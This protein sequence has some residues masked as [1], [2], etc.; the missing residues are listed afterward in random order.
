MVN[1]KNIA[2]LASSKSFLDSRKQLIS[3]LVAAGHKV[4]CI[5]PDNLPNQPFPDHGAEFYGLPLEK[6][7]LNPFKDLQFLLRLKKMFKRLKPDMVL[8]YTI[9]PVIYGCI[10]ANLVGVKEINAIIAGL[11]Y[12][13]GND[14]KQQK[15]AGI[16][17]KNLYRLALRNCNQVIFQNPDDMQE[18]L[19][20]GIVNDRQSS[21]VNGS[22]V[23]L[24]HFRFT[25]PPAEPVFILIARMLR[26]KG[27]VEFIEAA[28]RLK[29]DFPALRF[30]IVGPE[31]SGPSALSLAQ[32][33]ALAA[34]GDIEVSGKVD[35]VRPVLQN[36]SLFVLP[37]YYREGVPRIILEAMAIGRAIVT[38]DAPGCRETV[39]DGEN[40][41]LVEPR[42]VESLYLAMKKFVADPELIRTMGK[43]SRRIAE[44]KFDVHRVNDL[45]LHRLGLT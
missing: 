30:K 4:T 5:V 28:T 3:R 13:F 2:I 18:F 37:S 23:D 7:G 43:N 44:Q 6:A 24:E 17:A 32:V 1:R 31:E 38:T 42:N 26:E 33:K 21:Q 12:A 9:K 11:G 15:I 40:G 36:S 25:A 45:L 41:F 27:V 10:A 35:D 14:S 29:K 39:I 34:P 19:Q 16:M 22:G 20:W 8:A